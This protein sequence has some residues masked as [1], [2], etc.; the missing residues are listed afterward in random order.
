ML[1]GGGPAFVTV[2]GPLKIT[3]MHRYC[4]PIILI[5]IVIVFQLSS[6][7]LLLFS[8]YPQLVLFLG[9]AGVYPSPFELQPGQWTVDH[10]FM[11]TN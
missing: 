3:K 9:E 11:I 1:G 8:N 4:S 5:V 10:H 6:M 7:L 2:S